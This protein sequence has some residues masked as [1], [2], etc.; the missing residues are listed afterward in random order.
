MSPSTTR[1]RAG[2]RDWFRD[3]AQSWASFRFEATEVRDLG[4]RVLV[5]G[6][7]HACGRASGA[8]VDNQ[9]GWIVEFKDGR[10]TSL[11]GFHDQAGALAAEGL[12]E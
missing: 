10:A 3:V 9:W 1:G 7:V 5:L 12:S 8:E 4:D 11:R 6:D 2:I